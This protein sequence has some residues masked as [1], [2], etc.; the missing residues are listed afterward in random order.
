MRTL[1]TVLVCL[2][3]LAQTVQG[4]VKARSQTFSIQPPARP[5]SLSATA[6]FSEPS[7]NGYLD[8]GEKGTINVTVANSGGTAAKNVVARLS[9]EGS[10]PGLVLTDRVT[11]GEIASNASGTGMIEVTAL[12]TVQTGLLKFTVEVVADNN[13]KAEP[14]SLSFSTLAAA[15]P[16]TLAVTVEFSEPSGNKLLDAGEKGTIKVTVSNT[17]GS[18]AKNVLAKL[19]SAA[20][21]VGIDFSKSV[22]IGDVAPSSTRAGQFEVSAFDYVQSQTFSLTVEVSADNGVKADPRPVSFSTRAA[23]RPA[24]L[25]A[26]VQFSEP[27]GNGILDPGETGTVTVS[28]TNTGG[29]PAKGVI[30]RAKTQVD[31]SGVTFP[32]VVQVGDIA[33]T[34]SGTARIPVQASETVRSQTISLTLEAAD[35]GGIAAEAKTLA[36]TTR[37]RVLARDTAP[38]DIEVWEPVVTASRGVKIVPS[39]SKFATQSSSVIVRGIAKDTSGVAVVTI[40]GQEARLSTG[41]EGFEFVGEA[42]LVLGENDVEVRALDRFKN[43]NKLTFRVTRNPETLAERRQIPAALFKGQRWAVIVGIS[44]YRSTDIPQLRYADQ[45]AQEFYK[46]MTKSI[47]E[48]GVGVPKSNV[49]FLLNDQATST[50]VREALTD[51]LKLAIEDDYVFIYFAGHGAPD[52]D[53]PKILYLLTHDS[54]LNRLAATSVKMQEIQDALRDYVAAKTVL[55]FADACHSRGVTGAVATRALAPPELVN[56]FLSELARAR[57]STMTFSASDVNQLSQEDKRWGGGH[58]VFTWYLLEGLRGK[59]DL[60]SDQMVRLGELTQFVSDNVRRDTRSQQSPI[61]S[62]NFDINLPLTI[63][64]DRPSPEKR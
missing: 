20:T 31:V 24:I 3:L 57:A 56:D 16:A 38:P 25:A 51:F 58:G 22:T 52:P 42:L 1:T 2:V 15:A 36:I 64:T 32:A 5:A 7:G 37:E 12:G 61:S 10:T 11:I 33:P 50:N 28:I 27:S 26:T 17:G 14:K 55:V 49:R 34:A 40:N 59:A 47:E 45:D 23:V 29:T 4:Q 8:A 18:T 53:R 63:V 39:D 35:A 62:G 41:A 19:S 9:A 44:R 21:A 13:V 43:E 48:G 54:D 60:N 6:E 46:I 30:V